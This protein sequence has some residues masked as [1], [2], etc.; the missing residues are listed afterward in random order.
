MVNFLKISVRKLAVVTVGTSVLRGK[1]GKNTVNYK[2]TNQHNREE[3]KNA[4]VHVMGVKI[5]QYIIRVQNKSDPSPFL[6]YTP[7]TEQPGEDIPRRS[8]R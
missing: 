2:N 8:A 3:R 5:R 6:P 1:V 4:G 7:N